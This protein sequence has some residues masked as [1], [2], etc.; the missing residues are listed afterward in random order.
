MLFQVKI[1]TFFK[2]KHIQNKD[3]FL[4]LFTSPTDKEK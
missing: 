2:T 1:K 3:Q 4:G